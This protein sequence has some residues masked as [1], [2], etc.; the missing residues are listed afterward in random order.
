MTSFTNH[1]YALGERCN[2][3]LGK[4]RSAGIKYV[5]G[6]VSKITDVTEPEV[7]I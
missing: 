4:R 1:V 2:E 7:N 3:R 6:S 5:C